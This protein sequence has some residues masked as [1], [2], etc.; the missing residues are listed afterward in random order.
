MIKRN[1]VFAYIPQV[2]FSILLAY[3]ILM[4][5]ISTDF[6]YH[7]DEQ[8]VILA[9][10]NSISTGLLLPRRYNYPSMTYNVSILTAFVDPNV[11]TLAIR[12]I[13]RGE[14][15]N[16]EDIVRLL[17]GTAF[18]LKLRSIFF[19]LCMFI[20]IPVYFLV[21]QLSKNAWI[22]LYS[23]LASISAW[24]Y[25]YHARWVAPDGLLALF[26]SWSLLSQY[27]ILTSER[28]NQRIAWVIISAIFA[29]FCIGTKYPGGIVLIPLLISII[30]S[31]RRNKST[32]LPILLAIGLIVPAT[33]FIITTPGSLLEPIKF[34]H[35]V[36]F[37]MAH[38]SQGH[39]GYSVNSFWEHFSKLFVYL[40]SVLL[41]KN[42]VLALAATMFAVLGAFYLLKSHIEIGIWFLSLPIFY[43]L[44]MST[45]SVMIVRNYILLLPFF[46]ILM[47]LGLYA[48]T[49]AAQNRYGL[50]FLLGTA[51][52][53][54]IVYNM[55]VMTKSS[56]SIFRPHTISVKSA[57]ESR[58]I[59][60]PEIRFFLS[61]RS[62]DFLG[63]ASGSK[64]YN[65]TDSIDLA[66]RFIFF[67]SE[68]SDWKLFL[69]NVP[70]RYR[71]I[72]SELDEV[73]WDFYPSWEGHSRVLEISAKEKDLN[74]LISGI[75]IKDFRR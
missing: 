59:S 70:S 7:W 75:L 37:E 61:P 69:A 4:G 42:T 30:I 40:T 19:L 18:R 71:T 3:V 11:V 67:S 25:I 13:K 52:F 68:V 60:S 28:Q 46:A 74:P 51:A 58:L 38:Y 50:R 72:W 5:I 54:F 41:S 24:E 10:Q 26:V 73:N 39:G 22:A 2:L 56:L 44:Y 43:S 63:V 6:G 62:F 23:G 49:S 14:K 32:A 64:H 12:T 55:S 53:F 66:D 27:Q 15:P 35:N 17:N 9:V 48:T 45:Q 33:V 8:R 20:G 16:T 47:G 36:R 29:G 21:K 57:I 65:I 34:L 31:H 1:V